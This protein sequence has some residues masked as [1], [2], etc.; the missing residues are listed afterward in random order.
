M[1]RI[2]TDENKELKIVKF[3]L[4]TLQL[5]YLDIHSP[6]NPLAFSYPVM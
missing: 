3:N 4:I 5:K 6:K 2:E 1:R